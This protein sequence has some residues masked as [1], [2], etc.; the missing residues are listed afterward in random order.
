MQKSIELKFKNAKA[1]S[2]HF[3]R[4]QVLSKMKEGSTLAQPVDQDTRLLVIHLKRRVSNNEGQVQVAVIEK[5]NFQEWL[6][7]Q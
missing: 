4:D 2:L 6:A 5:L 3:W 1:Q 7:K